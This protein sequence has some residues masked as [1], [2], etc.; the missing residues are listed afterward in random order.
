MSIIQA[1]T[2]TVLPQYNYAKTK[3][4]ML[5]HAFLYLFLLLT[6]PLHASDSLSLEIV[7]RL[8]NLMTDSL[9]RHSQL[10]LYVLCKQPHH[11]CFSFHQ[12]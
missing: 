12:G 7:R 10:G 11:G 9:L 8:D 1:V 5:K 6:L 4:N 2:Y 3:M